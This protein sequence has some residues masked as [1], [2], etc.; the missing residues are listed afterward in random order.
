MLK[1][2]K[3]VLLNAEK[4]DDILCNIKGLLVNASGK[5]NVLFET[6]DEVDAFIDEVQDIIEKELL[7][8]EWKS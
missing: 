7:A 6:E 2:N 4:M 1:G 3:Q 5:P 8:G